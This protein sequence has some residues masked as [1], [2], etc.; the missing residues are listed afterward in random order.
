MRHPSALAE[1]FLRQTGGMATTARRPLPRSCHKRSRR[2]LTDLPDEVLIRIILMTGCNVSVHALALTCQRMFVLCESAVFVES[3]GVVEA[4][5]YKHQRHAIQW[6][7][8]RERRTTQALPLRGFGCQDLDA[9]FRVLW[10]CQADDPF[11]CLAIWTELPLYNPLRS[12]CSN[13]C[14]VLAGA[15][16]QVLRATPDPAAWLPN[17]PIAPE[18]GTVTGSA[19]TANIVPSGFSLYMSRG[20]AM[21]RAFWGFASSNPQ[22]LRYGRRTFDQTP[23]GLFCEE[24]GL[25]M[26][27]TALSVIARTP[28]L[29][30]I[31]DKACRKDNFA[32]LR[33]MIAYW[34]RV[35]QRARELNYQSCA[36]AASYCGNIC[37]R[38]S[39][40][41]PICGGRDTTAWRCLDEE[42]SIVPFPPEIPAFRHQWKG[43]SVAFWPRVQGEGTKEGHRLQHSL[44]SD[45]TRVCYAGT[46][47]ISELP[48]GEAAPKKRRLS[49]TAQRV[50]GKVG[51]NGTGGMPPP[52]AM[53]THVSIE[54]RAALSTCPDW[55]LLLPTAATLV[56]FP[57]IFF[58]HWTSHWL[59]W[60][61]Q[62][63]SPGALQTYVSAHD[64]EGVSRFRLAAAR[65]VFVNMDL[66]AAE[67][68]RVTKSPSHSAEQRPER[69]GLYAIACED[70]GPVVRQFEKATA[71]TAAAGINT[72]GDVDDAFDMHMERLWAPRTESVEEAFNRMSDKNVE[73]LFWACLEYMQTQCG[74][75]PGGRDKKYS[76]SS[77][78]QK[79]RQCH[80]SS[81]DQLPL[82]L[83]RR[84]AVGLDPDFRSR[85]PL[86]GVL[87]HRIIFDEGCELDKMGDVAGIHFMCQM[88]RAEGKWAMPRTVLAQNSGHPAPDALRRLLGFVGHPAVWSSPASTTFVGV[89]PSAAARHIGADISDG[90]SQTGRD[91]GRKRNGEAHIEH[92]SGPGV[93]GGDHKIERAE[94]SPKGAT[95]PSSGHRSS[96][97]D[98]RR[99]ERVQAQLVTP[100]LL[101]YAIFSETAVTHT[102]SRVLTLP[103]LVGPTI[104]RLEPLK[105][106]IASYNDL[107]E[108]SQRNLFLTYFHPANE[109]SLLHSAN[110]GNTK[111]ILSS[112]QLTWLFPACIWAS[113]LPQHIRQTLEMLPRCKPDQSFQGYYNHYLYPHEPVRVLVSFSQVTM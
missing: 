109:K 27:V 45:T 54:N 70:L 111:Q 49:E 57:H 15:E 75:L 63:W 23:G 72:L 4:A 35:R 32:R 112:A 60:F 44:V 74:V 89:G 82:R 94:R 67:A 11:R 98:R 40:G 64:L 31:W 91:S 8:H 37:G 22:L 13:C 6:M 101:T 88:L 62:L 92:N 46:Q 1:L 73:V 34:K 104:F 100:T 16:G 107:V 52:N 47:Q 43:G 105:E 58:S 7:G 95:A 97:G 69:G 24:P 12:F 81:S 80:S 29:S 5:L 71:N 96:A 65:V 9:Y 36:R 61:P 87:W 39:A 28:R 86:L 42:T 2:R 56:I 84:Q 51:C 102:K 93:A 19:A 106:E 79:R 26:T 41:H 48:L 33:R 3:R 68:V 50:V 21:R 14:C 108:L 17:G 55:E 110:K 113:V 38:A 10:M 103:R 53:D 85:S 66:V 83:H 90:V 99:R 20:G 59:R 77:S 25:G 78:R 76:S 30:L 18:A